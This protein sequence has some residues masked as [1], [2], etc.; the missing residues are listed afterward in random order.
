MQPELHLKRRTLI[1]EKAWFMWLWLVLLPPLGIAIMWRQGRLS[2]G[3]RLTTTLIASIY[4]LSPFILAGFATVPLF[5]NQDDFIKAYE[6][7]SN[8]LDLPYTLKETKSEGNSITSKMTKDITVIENI[9]QSGQVHEL[10][11]IGQGEG[12]DIVLSMG[13]IVEM[14]NPELKSNEVR[15]VL[16][17]LRLFD[18][19]YKFENNETTVEKNTIRYNLKYKQDIGL[20]FSVSKVN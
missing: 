8:E 17:E 19:N 2:K 18:E 4:F 5:Y 20:I 10:I 14:T 12:T 6:N 7:E 11:M 9:D 16:E 15:K 1:F 13:L 3:R